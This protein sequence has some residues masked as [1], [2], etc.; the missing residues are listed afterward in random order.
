M[1]SVVETSPSSITS[2]IQ[3]LIAEQNFALPML[4]GFPIVRPSVLNGGEDR[5]G[6]LAF[7]VSPELAL[8]M[9]IG[10]DTWIKINESFSN[11][12]TGLL[13]GGEIAWT[14]GLTFQ[15]NSGTYAVYGTPGS[16]DGGPAV[17]DAAHPTLDRID[18]IGYNLA[19]DVIVVT[20]VPSADPAKPQVDPLT[21]LELTNV[22]VQAGATTPGNISTTVVYDENTEFTTFAS[23][24]SSVNFDNLV[25]PLN[26]LK[27]IAAGNFNASSYMEF[28]FPSAGELNLL[29]FSNILL[30]IRL[31]STF[32]ASNGFRITFYDDAGV[33][34]TST[35]TVSNGSYG[36]VRTTTGTYQSIIIPI[37]AFAVYASG[38]KKMRITMTNTGSANF[39]MDYIQLQKGINQTVSGVV[40]N[41]QQVTAVGNATPLPIFAD[42]F[43]LLN[44]K[45][46]MYTDDSGNGVM[47]VSDL[48]GEFIYIDSQG[49]GTIYFNRSNYP[50]KLV[51]PLGP[52]IAPV[53]LTMPLA[54]GVLVL[55]VNGVTADAEGNIS[56]TIDG[57]PD[58]TGNAGKYLTTDG[59][60]AS[61]ADVDSLPDQTG[62]A[63]KFLKTDGTVAS[64]ES[65]ILALLTGY[66]A[67][68]GTITSA[69][70]IL[71][72]IQKLDGNLALTNI[73]VGQIQVGNNLYN[74]YNFR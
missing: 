59:T 2:L 36:F 29:E 22:L 64:W 24:L 68:A 8:I 26:L 60:D 3:R 25:S 37:S 63:G 72:A 62:N 5:P 58:Q 17:L 42:R 54:T 34:I 11:L 69:D 57:L 66:A 52:M 61:W 43:G 56:L 38:M 50:L 39:K 27:A 20:G 12:F 49:G 1:S 30:Y 55:S 40:P 45:A 7:V 44:G 23:W 28:T 53:T 71:T 31:E 14:G 6:S 74:Y 67:A 47:V 35:V 10:G 33:A 15:V 4:E 73:L 13:T 70:S 19:G 46:T 51:A 18:V 21:E 65:V 41:L 48:T 32:S 16:S 9:Y